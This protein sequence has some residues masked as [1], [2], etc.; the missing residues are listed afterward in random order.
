MTRKS[1][2]G[3]RRTIPVREPRWSRR[4]SARPDEILAAALACFVE[5]GFGGTR[6]DE[7]AERAGIAKGTLYRY[8]ASKDALFKAVVRNQL[9]SLIGE[10]EFA[11]N[12]DRRASAL[13]EA[14]LRDLEMKMATAAGALP[15]VVLAEAA[16]FPELAHF[17]AEEIIERG[18]GV[19]QQLIE[20]GIRAG[21]FV[22]VEPRATAFCIVSPLILDALFRT[23]LSPHIDRGAR[24]TALSQ[25]QMALV[26]LGLH[27]RASSKTWSRRLPTS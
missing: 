15:R 25:T 24:F 26:T 5:K 12:D 14:F 10:A 4:K 13:L 17:Y 23:G 3:R 21:E 7:V 19:L 16:S 18:V 9:G 6:L 2:R 27:P 11:L 22:P 20:R 1:S 8:F